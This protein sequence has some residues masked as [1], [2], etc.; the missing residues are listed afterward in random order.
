VSAPDEQTDGPRDWEARTYDRVA[1][2]HQAWGA[3]VVGRLELHGDEIVVDAGCGTGRVTATLVPLVPRGRVIGVDGSPSMIEQARH[4]LPAGVDLQV[5]DLTE[6]VLPA[7][8]DAIVSTATFHWIADHE[9]LFRRLAA[10]LKPGG[11]LQAQCGGAGNI[12]S[13]VA[14]I[15]R[16]RARPP[17]ADAFVGFDDDWTFAGPEETTRRLQDAGFVD[18]ECWLEPRPVRLDDPHA[19]LRTV[20]LGSYL[21]RLPEDAQDA[22]VE[23]VRAELDG[24]DGVVLDYVRLNMSATRADDRPPAETPE[25]IAA[26]LRGG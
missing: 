21:A 2:P 8:V 20:V 14:A 24:P 1:V 10:A 3:D 23:D 4:V 25:A 11:Q 22:F 26:R 7:P 16:L 9:R 12:A 18:V 13:V 19:F 15:A 17:W 5:Q 6:L